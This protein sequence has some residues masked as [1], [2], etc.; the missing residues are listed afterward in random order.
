MIPNSQ[1]SLTIRNARIFDGES[2]A[3][4]EGSI[5]IRDGRVTAV[6][7]TDEDTGAGNILD[8]G[9][10]VVIPG[11][12]DAHFHAYA[13]SLT[14]AINE[15]GPLSYS[16]LAGARRLEAALG[17][18]FTSV[19]DVAGGDVGLATAIEEGLYPG[20]RY[21]FTG[22]ALSQTGGHGDIRA[23]NDASCFHGGHM[24][25]VVDGVEDLLLAVRHRFRTGATAIKIMTSGG[26]IS[27]VDPIRVPQYSAAEIRVVTEEASRRGS[28]ATAHAY[29]PEAITH[30]VLNGVRCIEHGNLLDAQTARLMA[31]NDVYLIPT[32]VTY[33]AMGRRGAEIGLTEV[34]V[35]KNQEVLAAGKNAVTLARDAGVRIGFGSDLMGELEDEQLAGLR[36]QCEVLGVYDTLRSATST[37]AALLRRDDLGRIAKGA[38]ADFVILDG[39]PFDEPSVLW[40]ERRNRTVI[41]AGHIVLSGGLPVTSVITDEVT[42]GASA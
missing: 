23:A 18:G 22:P 24:C 2:P 28:Y 10:R 6:G 17:R 21:F 34:G 40:D 7:S 20:P 9:G 33:D 29:S 11:L 38:C 32:L 27:P 42:S 12:I 3:L 5:V 26:V 16:A 19:R 35:A 4:I 30:S 8:A 1:G 13:L 15:T 36:L 14:S 25:E 39:N 31:E 41:K 37:N